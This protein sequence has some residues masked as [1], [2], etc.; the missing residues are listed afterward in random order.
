MAGIAYGTFAHWAQR[1]KKQREAATVVKPG[2]LRLVEATVET[3]RP[4][5]AP[6]PQVAGLLVEL[7]CGGRLRVESP[8]QLRLAAELLSLMAQGKNQN[9]GW[10]C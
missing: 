4:E 6:L 10:R 3:E 9:G 5:A 8:M 1:R 2:A 7:P